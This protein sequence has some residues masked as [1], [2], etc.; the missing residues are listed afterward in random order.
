MVKQLQGDVIV[1]SSENIVMLWGAY[2]PTKKTAAAVPNSL[3]WNDQ[4]AVKKGMAFDI[5][6]ESGG[7]QVCRVEIKNSS[8][9]YGCKTKNTI[10]PT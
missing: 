6:G 4:N 10:R 1:D 3:F 7:Y 8:V 2:D 9:E 5:A